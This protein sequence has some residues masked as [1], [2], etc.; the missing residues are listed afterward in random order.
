M[1]TIFSKIINGDLPSEK[2]FENERIVAIKDISPKA[3]VHLLIIPKK[4]FHDVSRIEE[5]DWPLMGEMLAVANQLAEEF[6]TQEG[7]RLIINKGEP[8]GQTVFHLHMHLLG[9]RNLGV[10]G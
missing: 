6:G 8:S 3:P 5:A 9:G 10:M 1:T 4:E 7:Y 2:V